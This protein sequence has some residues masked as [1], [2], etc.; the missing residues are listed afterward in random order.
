MNRCFAI[1]LGVVL[2][3][4]AGCV[5]ATPPPTSVPSAATPV[6]PTIAPELPTVT[7]TPPTVLLIS[8]TP[9]FTPSSRA[10]GDGMVNGWA[11]LAE[12]DSYDDVKMTN[13]PIGYTNT[14]QLRQLLLSSGWQ[15]KRI[16]EAREFDQASLRQSPDWLANNADADDMALLYVA[17]HGKYITDVVKWSDFIAAD[18]AAV[19][20]Q[21]R[22]LVMDTCQAGML[23][24]AVK[25]D[26]HPY[27]AIAAVDVGEY[28]WSG[29]EEEKLPIIGGV[30]TH[31]F[32]A[33][34]SDPK[35]DA[36]GDGQ[37]SIQ[38]AARHAE[39]Q[40][41]TYMHDVVL[42]VPQFLDGYHKLGSYPE[43]DPG[44]PHVIV[45]DVVGE[46]VYLRLDSESNSRPVP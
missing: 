18:W 44:F 46:P 4:V 45:D 5:C 43:R 24:A 19:P 27:L 10:T 13:L 26:S 23:T 15:E 6:S 22:I 34:F 16:R 36:D 14:L 28:G 2:A 30:F 38:E 42:A 25:S 8:A 29:L 40:Q 1:L 9:I 35:A 32:A 20:S 3:L 11:V 33:A 31:Y 12:K 37:V 21:K 7:P 41:R 17:A 39:T